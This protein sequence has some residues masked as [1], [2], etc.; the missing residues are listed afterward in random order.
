MDKF[1]ERLKQI[2]KNRGF[3][4]TTASVM[5]ARAGNSVMRAKQ[6]W[7]EYELGHKFPNIHKLYDIC[8]AFG[9]SAD[10]LLGLSDKEERSNKNG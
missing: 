7:S 2:R 3:N 9:C 10:Y 1:G 5:V 4:Q 6:Q 8:V